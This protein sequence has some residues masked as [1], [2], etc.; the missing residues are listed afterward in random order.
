M[1]ARRKI[2]QVGDTLDD[3]EIFIRLAH[4]LGLNRAFP[5]K[6]HA[7]LTRWVLEGT[8]VR[9]E[10]FCERGILKGKARFHAQKNDKTFFKTPSGKFEIAAPALLNIG[11]SPL[12]VY[13]EPAQS[14]VSKPAVAG[15]F[16][17]ILIGGV[18]L[19]FFRRRTESHRSGD[20]SN[21]VVQILRS[22]ARGIT[23]GDW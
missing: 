16:P 7:D 4:R 20:E 23:E 13:R 11:V 10:E 19:P 9:F 15:K 17:L 3:Q 18:R 2:I 1:L 22:C 6:D 12:P 21:P 8:G 14:P 5:W